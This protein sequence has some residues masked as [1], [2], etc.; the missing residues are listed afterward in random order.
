MLRKEFNA[1]CPHATHI[2]LDTLV[3]D[4]LEAEEINTMLH[5][6]F[7]ASWPPPPLLVLASPV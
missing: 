4:A 7:H 1:S 6:E 5:K 3:K 2:D